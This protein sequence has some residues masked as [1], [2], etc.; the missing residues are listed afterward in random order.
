MRTKLTVDDIAKRIANALMFKVGMPAHYLRVL[1]EMSPE[2]RELTVAKANEL[3]IKGS[4]LL[5]ELT[6]K[7]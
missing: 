4:T 7:L 6:S 2:D 5:R 3:R 1:V